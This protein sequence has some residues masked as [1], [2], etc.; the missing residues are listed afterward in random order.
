MFGDNV[1]LGER[2]VDAGG[3][4]NGAA[5]P[6]DGAGAGPRQ[7]H[8]PARVVLGVIGLD[9]EQGRPAPAQPHHLV[10]LFLHAPDERPTRLRRDAPLLLQP[11]LEFVFFCT[12][13]T[14]WYEMS[15]TSSKCP[16]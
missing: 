7:G 5:A 11:G 4:E 1:R 2:G 14:V 12:R 9:V 8:E 6:V 10:P 3:V 15:S 13:R 16:T